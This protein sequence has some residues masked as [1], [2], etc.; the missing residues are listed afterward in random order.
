MWRCTRLLFEVSLD[1]WAVDAAFFWM[2]RLRS[3]DFANSR[4]AQ[5]SRQHTALVGPLLVLVERLVAAGLRREAEEALDWAQK[6]RARVREHGNQPE[7]YF[8]E[9]SAKAQAIVSG[10]KKP[11]FILNHMRQVDNAFRLGAIN[12]KRYEHDMRRIQQRLVD[13]AAALQRSEE[14]L[15][16]TKFI[17]A[18]PTDRLAQRVPLDGTLV[19]EPWYY[20]IRI[21]S[22]VPEQQTQ[23]LEAFESGRDLKLIRAYLWVRLSSLIRSAIFHPEEVDLPAI[24]AELQSLADIDPG[25]AQRVEPA[26]S[27]VNVISALSDDRRSS[28]AQEVR[29]LLSAQDVNGVSVPRLLPAELDVRF[30]ESALAAGRRTLGRD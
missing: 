26:I 20:Q 30:L 19:P 14:A 4:Y 23:Y 25:C 1:E 9:P 17:P 3:E 10:S 24:R 21:T 18:L 16:I 8:T 7:F 6:C 2:G 27:I 11:Y 22:L 29:Q 28:Y 15:R 12:A 5:N 13:R